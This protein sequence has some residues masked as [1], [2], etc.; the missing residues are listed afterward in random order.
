MI[1]SIFPFLVAHPVLFIGLSYTRPSS[2]A[3]FTLQGIIFI[4]CFISRLSTL[5][6]SIPGQAGGQYIYGMMMQS[7]HFMLLAKATPAAYGKPGNELKWSMDMLFSAR[8][9][10]SSKMLPPFRRKDRSYIPTKARFLVTRSWDLI[11]TAALI[12][13]INHYRL[14]IWPDDFTTVPD[15]FLR[16]IPSVTAREWVIRIYIAIVG[17]FE[18]YLALRAGH[19][20]VS[21]IGVGVLGDIPE[22]YPPLF[23]SVKEAY[24]V[25]RFYM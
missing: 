23:G 9:G 25:R 17:K 18:P 8:W 4:C 13:V 5:S 6:L 14:N 7:S 21:I 11:W 16:R 2:P 22:R 10:V 1:D 12:Y 3:R 20:L 19:S 15:G 24:S